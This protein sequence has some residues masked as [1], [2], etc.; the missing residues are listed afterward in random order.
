MNC[1]GLK[2]SPVVVSLTVDLERPV[3]EVTVVVQQSNEEDA[4]DYP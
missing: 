1:V 3:T 2:T 4:Q